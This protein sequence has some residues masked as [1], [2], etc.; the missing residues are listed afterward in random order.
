MSLDQGY[1]QRVQANSAEKQ[2]RNYPLETN[3][4]SHSENFY[5]TMTE[6]R[7]L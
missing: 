1:M 7:L 2:Y 6:W 4:T 3:I 5:F